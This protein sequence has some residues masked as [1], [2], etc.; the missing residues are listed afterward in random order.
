MARATALVAIATAASA[1]EKPAPPIGQAAACEE[2]RQAS[3][4]VHDQV[5]VV[6][7]H[8]RCPARWLPGGLSCGIG[9]DAERAFWVALRVVGRR[10]LPLAAS[11]W[12]SPFAQPVAVAHCQGRAEAARAGPD[13]FDA[14]VVPLAA[15]AIPNLNLDFQQMGVNADR[16]PALRHVTA[17]CQQR[18]G[19]GGCGSTGREKPESGRHGR[20]QRSLSLLYSQP[21]PGLLDVEARGASGTGVRQPCT[22]GLRMSS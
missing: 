10:R 17:L 2:G 18:V 15:R 13:A 6:V 16:P 19:T 21:H 8:V 7:A 3:S 4:L 1:G 14:M 11:S 20:C 5:V 22:A 9:R 12:M